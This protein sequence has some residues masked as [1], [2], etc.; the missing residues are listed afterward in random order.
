MSSSFDFHLMPISREAG[1][2]QPG[3][4]GLLSTPAPR[5]AARGRESDHLI[6]YLEVVGN[7][8][9]PRERLQ[10][11]LPGL[12]KIYFESAGSRSYAMRG[13]AEG[14]NDHLLKFNLQEAL[15]GQQA[16]GLLTQV[17]LHEDQLYMAQ[18]GAVHAFYLNEDGI[19]HLYE[20][21]LSGR[22]VGFGQTTP[23]RFFQSQVR[24]NT[25]LLLAA[26]PAPSWTTVSL[27]WVHGQGPAALRRRL[28]DRS[29]TNLSGLLIYAHAGKG[30]VQVVP[31]QQ[32]PQKLTGAQSVPVTEIPRKVQETTTAEPTGQPAAISTAQ[33]G[34][35][36]TQTEESTTASAV[37]LDQEGGSTVGS[38]KTGTESPELGAGADV[39]SL[40]GPEQPRI[41]PTSPVQ[42]KSQRPPKQ[43]GTFLAMLVTVGEAFG[44]FFHQIGRGLGKFLA[45]LFPE[46]LLEISNTA[47]AVIALAVPVI[48]VAAASVVYLQLGRAEQGRQYYL[49]ANNTAASALT[50]EDPLAQ[51][52]ELLSAEGYLKQAET[53]GGVPPARLD[54]LQVRINLELDR[55]DHILRIEYRQALVDALDPAV[56]I[57]R[58]VVD[59]DD[60]YMLDS[61][62]NRVLHAIETFQG[63]QVD[64]DFQCSPEYA[65]GGVGALVG[66][67]AWPDG[68]E[69]SASIMGMDHAGNLIFCEPGISPVVGRLASPPN[70]SL[71]KVTALTMDQASLYV[72]DPPS[73]AI[74][75]YPGAQIDLEP[76]LFF[77]DDI[78]P[79]NTVIDIAANLQEIYLLYSDGHLA[80]CFDAVPGIS[81]PKCTNPQPFLD[82]REGRENADFIPDRPFTQIVSNAS[83]DPSLY[84]LEPENQAVTQ[85]SFRSLGYL[86]EYR[87]VR[88]LDGGS[89]TAFAIR[90]VDRLV[91]LAVGSQVYFGVIP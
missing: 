70:T 63:Y 20:P 15:G 62:G 80:L 84:L 47:M 57:S 26:R 78:P 87:P 8:S 74:W 48:I 38:V 79:L 90:G 25:V 33:T 77:G 19:Q 91:Y 7:A 68:Y 49:Q 54:E 67:S 13:V 30:M 21:S 10:Q 18:S 39:D 6:L 17:V 44:S 43:K 83:P 61:A 89:A 16:I 88:Q 85:F 81:Q 71:K 45:R 5:K 40:P 76:N 11:V 4:P 34:P 60:L 3:L 31:F 41:V 35:S 23:I 52:Q 73:N 58:L 65:G 1:Q 29:V 51:R 69:P 14:L 24:P 2:D 72:L 55:L 28:F 42:T 82:F 66:I 46:E 12:A 27:S 86:H 37:T 50:L 59:F 32:L 64:Q 22:G 56:R 53:S 36:A 75:F 9:F